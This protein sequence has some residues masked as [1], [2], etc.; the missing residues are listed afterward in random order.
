MVTDLLECLMSK[1]PPCN[2]YPYSPT[3][4][5]LIPRTGQYIFING[6]ATPVDPEYAEFVVNFYNIP[7]N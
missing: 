5:S 2:N 4:N 7:G 1:F 6:S 3:N